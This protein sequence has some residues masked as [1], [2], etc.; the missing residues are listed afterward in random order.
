MTDART[1]PVL[2]W[3]TGYS[4]Q[5]WATLLGRYDALMGPGKL[6][7]LFGFIPMMHDLRPDS[8]KRFRL[9]ADIVTQGAGL[10]GGMP[11]PPVCSMIPGHW[12]TIIGNPEGIEA[13]LFLAKRIGGRRE[14]VADILA[15]AWLHSGMRGMAVAA[16]VARPLL[17]SW[18]PDQDGPG[19]SWPAGWAPDDA[20]FASGVDFLAYAGVSTADPADIARIV[21]WHE[22]VQGEVPPYVAFFAEHFP[23]AVI[24]FRARFESL[25]SGSLPKQFIALCQVQ[26]AAGWMQPAGLRRAL[27]LAREFGV[28]KDQVAQVL[29]YSQIFLG[30][31]GTDAVIAEASTFF[32]TW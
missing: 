2:D 20:A 25:L 7:E 5:E 28:E 23:M 11:N 3:T 17:E 24:G 26:L 27:H 10:A 15:M 13:D 31:L 12:N 9:V 30:D 18:T 16:R 32:A 8:L 21:A 19:L 22:R 14:E 1:M 6:D 29:G 4:D